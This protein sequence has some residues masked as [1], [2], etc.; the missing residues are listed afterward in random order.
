MQLAGGNAQNAPVDISV[1]IPVYNVERYLEECVH[2]VLGQQFDGRLEVILVDDGSTDSSGRLCDRLADEHEHIRVLH[3]SN[4][5]LSDAR[6]H[7][8]DVARGEYITFV[9]SDDA[10]LPDGLQNLWQMCVDLDC[11]AACAWMVRG[12][13]YPA[14]RIFSRK[15]V[16]VLSGLETVS[17]G[18]LQRDVHNSAWGKLYH[19]S[20]W[21]TM[22]YRKGIGY[23][24]LDIF[25]PLF[26]G[27]ERVAV[28]RTPVY[29]YRQ[30]SGS[31]LHSFSPSRA[32]VLDV[33]DRLTYWCTTQA[34]QLLPQA[35]VRRL[36]AHINIL[37]LLYASHLHIPRIESRC[38]SVIAHAAETVDAEPRTKLS[39]RI[40]SRLMSIVGTTPVM[41]LL[42]LLYRRR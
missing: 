7:G 26:A 9:D 8:L 23:E 42:A 24:D 25:A 34:P 35:R 20:L 11:R 13:Q 32:D 27:V 41:H 19:R 33:T 5:G 17:E 30:H 18:L 10:L 21:Q 16:R 1:I 39:L 4:G 28:S 12:A 6:N 14:D 22:R 40:A 15:P 3:K 37:G 29:F 38:R 2:S 36:S 31:Y